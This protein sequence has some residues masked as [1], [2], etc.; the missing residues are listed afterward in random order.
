LPESLRA[1]T[2][3][4]KGVSTQGDKPNWRPLLAVVGEQV[5]GDF[6]WMFEVELDNGMPLQAYKHV[7]TRGY[8]H[9]AP[10]GSAFIYEPPDR[11][12]SFPVAD[13]LAAVFAPLLGLAGVTADQISASW[14]AVK[15]LSLT[16]H[17]ASGTCSC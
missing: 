1:R 17:G 5:A 13:V 6:M 3:T 11:Y 7:D 16:H 15:R 10:D 8:V 4:Y 12:R 14:G 9:L 2:R